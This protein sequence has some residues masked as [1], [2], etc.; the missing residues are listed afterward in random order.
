MEAQKICPFMNGNYCQKDRCGLF[1]L[2]GN[3]CAVA[4]IGSS[5][6]SINSYGV[7]ADDFY[8]VKESI[9]KVADELAS[10]REKMY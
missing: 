6:A 9:D 1:A 3:T 8:D 4:Q 5:L 2:S 10:I 7:N